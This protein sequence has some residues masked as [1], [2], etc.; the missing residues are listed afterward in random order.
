MAWD[1]PHTC[2]NLT[3]GLETEWLTRQPSSDK[4]EAADDLKGRAV[5]DRAAFRVVS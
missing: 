3:F 5:V 4:L 2:G 1:N